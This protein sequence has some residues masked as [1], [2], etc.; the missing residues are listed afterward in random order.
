MRHL[1]KFRKL[2]RKASHRKS[3]LNNLATELFRYG[4]ITTTL[5]KTKELRRLADK[6]ITLAKR[7]DLSARRQA[8]RYIKDKEVS[9]KLFDIIGPRFQERKGGYTRII[10]TKRRIGD[11]AQ[12]AVIE[13]VE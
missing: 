7:G 5:A 4:K 3:L 1:K 12:L 11:G 13:L 10:K 2:Q 8:I 9:R 6:L